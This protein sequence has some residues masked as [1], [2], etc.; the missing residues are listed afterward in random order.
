MNEKKQRILDVGLIEFSEH[1]YENAS[2]N[3]IIEQADLSKGTFYHYF[4]DKMDLY[5]TL[6][7]VCIDKKSDYINSNPDKR[8]KYDLSDDFFE[9][10]KKQMLFNIGFLKQEPVFY[11]FS[12]HISSEDEQV[13]ASIR[14]KHGWRLDGGVDDMIDAAYLKGEF[15]TKYPKGF[16]KNVLNHL[17]KHYYYLLFP[18]DKDISPEAIEATLDLYYDFL[19]SGFSSKE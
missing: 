17:F 18:E 8:Y 9:T 4:K 6:V 16:V 3:K 12:V 13:K 2:L 7:N 14:E 11:K 1:S 10:I 5:L 15:D 19:K